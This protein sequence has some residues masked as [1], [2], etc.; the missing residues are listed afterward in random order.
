MWGKKQERASAPRFTTGKS[1]HV[2][3]NEAK[4]EVHAFCFKRDVRFI[5]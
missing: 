2:R 5:K 1:G 3:M 4:I